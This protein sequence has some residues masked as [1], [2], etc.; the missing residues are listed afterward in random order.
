MPLPS[1]WH[2]YDPSSPGWLH[3]RHRNGEVILPADVERILSADRASFADPL[4]QDHVLRALRGELK[5]PRGRRPCGPTRDLRLGV[6]A[7]LL[8][9]ETRAVRE[10]R[11]ARGITG[12]GALVEPCVEAADRLGDALRLPRGRTLLNEISSWKSRY[13]K[14]KA[15]PRPN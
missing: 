14:R 9:E 1:P 5:P 7:E 8:A 3:R 2:E 11:K 4:T 13:L 12:G 15:R 10:E 6:A